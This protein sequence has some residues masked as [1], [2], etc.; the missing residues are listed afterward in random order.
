MRKTFICKESGCTEQVIYE[1]NPIPAYRTQPPKRVYLTCSKG[2]THPYDL[3]DE[4]FS[5]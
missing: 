1:E 2:H 3:S 5:L 4:V